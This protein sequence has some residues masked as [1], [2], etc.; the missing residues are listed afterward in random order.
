VCPPSAE[1]RPASAGHPRNLQLDET[2][3]LLCGRLMW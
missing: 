1:V 3:V 2:K